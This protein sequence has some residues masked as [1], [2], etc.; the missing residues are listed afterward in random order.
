MI[1]AYTGL[2]WCELS[3]I[4][5]PCDPYKTQEAGCTCRDAAGN[6]ID[7][8]GA[9]V[10]IYSTPAATPLFGFP[11]LDAKTLGLA[12]GLVLVLILAKR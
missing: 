11:G 10:P 2:G 9:V 8:T 12:A 7:Q 4:K 1:A 6:L 3:D 5:P